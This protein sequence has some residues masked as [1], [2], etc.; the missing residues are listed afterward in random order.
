MSTL[1]ASVPTPARAVEKPRIGDQWLWIVVLSVAAALPY[2][3]TLGYGFV[4]DDGPQ[5]VEN[6]DLLSLHSIPGLFGQSISKTG[7]ANNTSQPVFYRPLFFSQLCVTRWLFGPG[8][9]GF[10]LFSL[11]LHIGNTLLFCTVALR[12]GLRKS[13]AYLAALLFA[14]HPV[15]V[16][17]VVWPSAT[18]DLMVF[19]AILCTLIAFL[20]SR[21][22]LSSGWS[23]TPWLALSLIAF[24]A[25]LLVKE[26]ALISL[27]LVAVVA[28]F[29]PEPQ[30][31]AIRR[32]AVVLAPY[33]A[34]TTFYLL[35]RQHAL[36]HFVATV[37][38]MSLSDMART[39]PSALWFYARHLMMPLRTSVLYD[40]DVV[41]HA[42][43]ATFWIPLV[44]VLA[45][46][47]GLAFFVWRHRSIAVVVATLLLLLPILM[48]LNFRIFNWGDL[49][50]DRY[51]Y[52]PSA[53]FCVLLA[54][55][56]VDLGSRFGSAIRP[57]VQRFLFGGLLCALALTTVSETLPWRNNLTLMMHAVAIAPGNVGSET[58]LGNELEARNDFTQAKIC[59]ERALQLA[60][61]WS[62]AWFAYGRVLLLTNDPHNAL[63]S[64]QR[65]LELDDRPITAVWLAAALDKLGRRQEAQSILSQATAQ[66]PS[67]FQAYAGLQQK[68]ISTAHN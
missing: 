55:G 41:E 54:I 2:V 58:L 63:R 62:E 31:T 59:Y 42:T 20:E 5:I 53:G 7:S 12:L 67:M 4:Y 35:V 57:A 8:P 51:L 11:L 1:T 22:S 65:S 27:P 15:H 44:L 68:L 16:E 29:E 23:R 24:L 10:H 25:G 6:R 9:F 38:P 56:G 49:V 66:D 37:S 14:V 21:R 52:T 33:V 13:V 46:L 30:T 48:V 36:R 45:C 47:G 43:V 26:T 17:A 39:W 34:I 19:A 28:L 50:H 32:L 18:P 64:L 40:Y 61:G 60:P 3:P